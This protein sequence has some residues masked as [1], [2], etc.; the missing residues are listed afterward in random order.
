MRVYAC[1]CFGVVGLFRNFHALI[2][3]REHAC[4]CVCEVVV[5]VPGRLH[6]PTRT[7][8][9]ICRISGADFEAEDSASAEGGRCEGGAAEEHPHHHVRALAAPKAALPPDFDPELP[10]PRGGDGLWRWRR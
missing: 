4:A 10:G 1:V 3:G 2:V 8:P 7:G 5:A 6:S 9:T